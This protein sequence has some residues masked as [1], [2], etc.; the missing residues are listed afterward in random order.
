VLSY[1]L[2]YSVIFTGFADGFPFL[3]ANQSS[4]DDLNDRLPT[5]IPMA[6]FRPK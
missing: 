2:D 3:L 1:F 4:L 5:P 6:R